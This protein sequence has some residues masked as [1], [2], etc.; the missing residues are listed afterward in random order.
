MRTAGRW[1]K[2]AP[3]NEDEYRWHTRNVPAARRLRKP[4]TPTED[5]LWRALRGRRFRGLKF[6]RQHPI[7]AYVLDFWCD[8]L[9]LA[10][11]VDGGIHDIASV[12][13]QDRG[14]QAALEELGVR[15]VRLHARLVEEDIEEALAVIAAV[16]PNAP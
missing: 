2:D 3:V 6:R 5:A 7:G 1:S 16:I 8:E 14:R 13:K 4:L 12:A 11:E 15:F 9:Q 10:V